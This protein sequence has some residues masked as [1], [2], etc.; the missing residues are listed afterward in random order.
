MIRKYLLPFVALLGFCFAVWMVVRGAKPVPAAR[1]VTQPAQSEYR[2]FVAGAGIVEPASEDIA[3]G[4]NLPGIVEKVF[5]SIGTRVKAGDPLFSIDSRQL[6]SEL[7]IRKAELK[8]AQDTVAR[9]QSMPRPEELPP[10]VA[11]VAAAEASL[12]DAKSALAMYDGVTDKR[13]IR[14][15]ELDRRRFAVQVAQARLEKAKAALS[16]TQAG[17]WKPE[18]EIAQAQA[19]AAAAQLNAV[20]TEVERLTVRA[21]IEGQVLRIKIRPGEYAQVGP[22]AT[23]LIVMGKTNPMHVRVD[24][25]EH[26]AWRVKAG[27]P[28]KASVRGN[29]SIETPLSFVRFEPY[30]IPKR[31]LTG[32]STERVDTRVLQV[33]YSFEPK[34]L[35]IFIGQQMDVFI[36]AEPYAV[37]APVTATTNKS[38]GE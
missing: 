35:Q 38:G 37:E 9:L 22:L 8:V 6:D 24:V 25:D 13:A 19:N 28:A 15:E 14:Q 23:S 2:A 10:L 18:I 33:V 4:T 27:S 16:L 31:S 21:P 26:E 11:E 7:A 17:A 34:E 3:I 20:K 36:D 5:V 32:E 29:R 1:P 12:G 30:V